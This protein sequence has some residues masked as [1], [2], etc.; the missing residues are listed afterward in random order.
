[1]RYQVQIK[2]KYGR[3]PDEWQDMD[4]GVYLTERE[5]L[6]RIRREKELDSKP[7]VAKHYTYRIQ[8]LR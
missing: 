4:N 7:P 8:E 5:A 3:H 2:S 6:D 1:M